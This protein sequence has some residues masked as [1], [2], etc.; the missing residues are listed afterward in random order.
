M[1]R[2]CVSLPMAK[3][4]QARLLLWKDLTL[5]FFLQTPM[6]YMSFQASYLEQ[7]SSY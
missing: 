1:E 7:L 3:L 5:A 4:V 6:R 2:M